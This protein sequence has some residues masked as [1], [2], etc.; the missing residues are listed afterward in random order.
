MKT[1][2]GGEMKNICVFAVC[3][4]MT[5]FGSCYAYQIKKGKAVATT[6]TWLI[7]LVGCGLS[8]ISYVIAENRDLRSGIMNTGDVVYA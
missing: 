3:F 7:F 6:S 5:V 2:K 1:K 8:F 4:L